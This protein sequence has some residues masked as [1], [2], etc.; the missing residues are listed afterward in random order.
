MSWVLWDIFLPVATAFAS[1]LFF[2]WLMWRWRRQSVDPE[3]LDAVRRYADSNKGARQGGDHRESSRLQQRRDDNTDARG[4]FGAA[5]VKAELTSAKKRIDTLRA[6]LKGTREEIV[7]LRASTAT[8]PGVTGAAK[9]SQTNR[10][11]DL[12]ARLQGALRKIS[13]MESAARGAGSNGSPS[14]KPPAQSIAGSNSDGRESAELL[15]LRDRLDARDKL[16]KTLQE[17]LAQYGAEKDSTVLTAEVALRDR[18]INAL[19]KLLNQTR[20]YDK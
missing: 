8:E 5:E 14:D 9:N 15:V 1:G 20:Q 16:I 19:E 18:K 10:E 11:R 6:E 12:E 7:S 2:G 17:S 3:L 4:S 13:D